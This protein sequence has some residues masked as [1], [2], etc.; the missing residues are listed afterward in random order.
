MQ[1]QTKRQPARQHGENVVEIK[2][3]NGFKDI[4]PED[5][6]RWQ[7]IEKTARDIFE[8]FG[9]REIRMPILEKTEFSE[10]SS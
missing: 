3:V 7:Q 6:L 9:M 8:R 5:A 1:V 10:Y 4:L 2:A